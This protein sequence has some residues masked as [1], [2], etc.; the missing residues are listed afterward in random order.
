MILKID[1]LTDRLGGEDDARGEYCR[2]K[3][4][5]IKVRFECL[6]TVGRKATECQKREGLAKPNARQ[7]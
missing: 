1:D 3:M 4:I 5:R 2:S 6:V 7:D